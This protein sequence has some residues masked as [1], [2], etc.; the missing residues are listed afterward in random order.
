MP[1]GIHT[2]DLWVEPAK[3]NNETKIRV[4]SEIRLIPRFR[5]QIDIFAIIKSDMSVVQVPLSIVDF[6]HN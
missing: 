3:P 6:Q 2:V 4:I 5:Q 1:N